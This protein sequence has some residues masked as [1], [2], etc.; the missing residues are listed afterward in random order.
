MFPLP[1]NLERIGSIENN[2]NV[3]HIVIIVV[4]LTGLY[5][6]I[7]I[8]RNSNRKKKLEKFE[9]LIIC[10]IKKHENA[11]TLKKSQLTYYDEYGCLIDSKWDKEIKHFVLNVLGIES[12]RGNSKVAKD[13]F[14]YYKNLINRNIPLVNI[15]LPEFNTTKNNQ[16]SGL[17]FE[18]NVGE[19]FIKN[20]F[21]VKYTPK[22]NDQGVDIIVKTLN[23]NT[24]VIQCKYYSSKIGN[25][26]V[27]EIISGRVFYNAKFAAVIT[28]NEYTTSAKQLAKTA[29][30]YLLHE[31]QI[32]IFC[33]SLKL[34]FD[35][36]CYYSV[37]VNVLIS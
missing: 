8:I 4:V 20:G 9:K 29:N 27:Q 36:F 24:L 2:F 16:E 21:Y 6:I 15:S 30:V 3:S 7:S 22:S 28:N 10:Y 34:D 11:L 33:D 19:R 37:V 13:N 25:Q 23:N 1:A 12:V 17:D 26:A 32:D 35:H 5:C 18:K 31:T 14:I